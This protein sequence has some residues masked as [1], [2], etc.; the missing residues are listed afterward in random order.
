ML[1]QELWDL[2]IGHLDG[3]IPSLKCCALTSTAFRPA[4]QKGIFSRIYVS[5]ISPSSYHGHTFGNLYTLLSTS[6]HVA[7]L[8]T[9]FELSLHHQSEAS[10]F[11]KILLILPLLCNVHRFFL[12]SATNLIF[13]WINLPVRVQESL[14]AFWHASNIVDLR[15]E[16]MGH[17]ALGEGSHLRMG[18]WSSLKHLAI[19]WSYPERLWE[20]NDRDSLPP[21]QLESLTVGYFNLDLTKHAGLDISFVRRFSAALEIEQNASS[22]PN[23]QDLLAQFQDTLEYLH[24]EMLLHRQR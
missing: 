9:S 15:I 1:P 3:D 2:I 10:E 7:P 21:P 23:I 19:L 4:S 22:V 13:E 18:G 6:P 24:L 20:R 12:L 16:A 14:V 11:E 5:S 17:M 8:I